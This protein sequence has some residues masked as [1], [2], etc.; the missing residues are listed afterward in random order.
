MNYVVTSP[1]APPLQGEG[2]KNKSKI[3]PPSLIGK[4]A[5][6]LGLVK[7]RSWQTRR[8]SPP[9]PPLRKQ[10]GGNITSPPRLRG[11]ARGGVLRD[12]YFLGEHSNFAQIARNLFPG[13]WTTQNPDFECEEFRPSVIDRQYHKFP[14][15]LLDLLK[16]EGIQ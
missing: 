9:Y 7:R 2:S 16:I 11:G 12:W 1:P 3:T 14:G 5:G 6:G 15:D 8:T 13:G 10:R 4:G